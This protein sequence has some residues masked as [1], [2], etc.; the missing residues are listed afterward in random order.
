MEGTALT[1]ARRHR[2]GMWEAE[3]SGGLRT[4][5]AGWCWGE[6]RGGGNVGG[7]GGPHCQ[8]QDA[9]GRGPQGPD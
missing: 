6:G 5:K 3:S 7:A 9:E 1:E 4:R 8:H 2:V